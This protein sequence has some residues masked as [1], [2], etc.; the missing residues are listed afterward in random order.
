MGTEY[1]PIPSA[2][3][4][5][6]GADGSIIGKRRY[7]LRP[8]LSPNGYLHFRM[9]RPG[10]TPV[11]RPVHVAVCEAFHGPRPDGQEVAHENGDKADNRA[12]N[13]SWKTRAANHADKIRHGT[14]VSGERHYA[15]KLTD[16]DVAVIRANY[17]VPHTEMARRYGVSAHHVYMIRN[18]RTR[19]NVTPRQ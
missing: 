12:V 6:A 13:L 15:A 10:H 9:S 11:T 4:Y 8:A 14:H 3:G 7:A 18:N 5:L 19:K 16:R 17:T 2:P 1:R